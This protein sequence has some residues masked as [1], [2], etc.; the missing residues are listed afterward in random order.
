M[1]LYFSPGACSLSPHVALREA[2]LPF[3]LVKVNLKTKQTADGR[4]FSKINPF[5]YVPALELDSGEVLT[6]GPAIVQYIADLA[7]VQKLAPAN[8]TWERYKLQSWLGFINSEIH[9]TLGGL[10]NPTL[11]VDAREAT[12]AKFKARLDQLEGVLGDGP[13]LLGEDFS[14]ADTYLYNVLGWTKYFQIDLSG[15]A[16]ISAH[17]ARIAARPAVQAAEAAEAA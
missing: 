8:G 7:P 17:R 13:Y 10:F 6:E 4:D 15:W 16:K 11:S 12:I 9:K 5:G 14:V 2:N 3:E 1:K